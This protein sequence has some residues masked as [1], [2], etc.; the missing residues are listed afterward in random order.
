MQKEFEEDRT[1]VYSGRITSMTPYDTEIKLDN[2][3]I[4]HVTPSDLAH[5]KATGHNKKLKLGERVYVLVKEVSIPH[6]IIYFNLSYKEL[7][8]PKQKVKK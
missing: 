2:N 1:K 7:S 3:V 6:R 4:G 8:K 5:A